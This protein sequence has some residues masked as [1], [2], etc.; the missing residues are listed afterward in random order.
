M[1][2]FVNEFAIKGIDISPSLV[3]FRVCTYSNPAVDVQNTA[4]THS[5]HKE[6]V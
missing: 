2:A 3:P 6:R 1:G 4:D 5:L